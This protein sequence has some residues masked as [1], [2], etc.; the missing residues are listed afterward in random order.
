MC[1]YALTEN[2]HRAIQLSAQPTPSSPCH[3]RKKPSKPT[4]NLISTKYASTV[5]IYTLQFLHFRLSR[6]NL[7]LKSGL[8]TS[9][10]SLSLPGQLSPCQSLSAPSPPSAQH[11]THSLTPLDLVASSF[12]SSVHQ[13]QHQPAA[14]TTSTSK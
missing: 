6:L 11:S 14:P 8:L 3:R 4:F 7:L 9:F 5:L 12:L 1:D 13:T 2:H 10:S